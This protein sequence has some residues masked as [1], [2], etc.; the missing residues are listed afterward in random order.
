MAHQYQRKLRVVVDEINAY[1]Y[2]RT[3]SVVDDEIRL[4]QIQ[5]STDM[6]SE[7][8]CQLVTTSLGKAGSYIAL[9]YCWGDPETKG[10]IIVSKRPMMVTKNLISALQDLRGRGYLRIWADAVCINQHNPEEKS[11]QILRM[12]G[13]Y[14]SAWKVVA[15]LHG[16]RFAEA[17]LA[18]ALIIRMYNEEKAA[19]KAMEEYK[20]K[21]KMEKDLGRFKDEG[22]WSKEGTWSLLFKCHQ[23]RERHQPSELRR[24][25]RLP[26]QIDDREH[27]VLY[28][29]LNNPYWCRSWIIQ[30]I[31]ANTQLEIIWG[32][33]RF[34]L[35]NLIHVGRLASESKGIQ[36]QNYG[37]LA[38]IQDLERIRTAQLTMQPHSIFQ[39]L[40]LTRN[41]KASEPRDRIYAIL[42]VTSNG[43]IL[44]PFPN[45]SLPDSAVNRDITSR[46]I[47]RTGRLD[48]VIFK[49]GEVGPWWHDWFSP[50]SFSHRRMQCCIN[51]PIKSEDS[52]E[53]EDYYDACNKRPAH[54]QFRNHSLFVEGFVVDDIMQCSPTLPEALQGG[55]KMESWKYIKGQNRRIDISWRKMKKQARILAW[56]LYGVDLQD[57]FSASYQVREA[58]LEKLLY[59]LRKS[60]KIETHSRLA[61]ELIQWLYCCCVESFVIK[62]YPLTSWLTGEEAKPNVKLDALTRFHTNLRWQMRL[63]STHQGRLGWFNRNALPGDKIA[64]I[65]GC[66]FPAVLRKCGQNRY[67]VVGEAIVQGLMF[68]EAMQEVQT[69]ELVDLHQKK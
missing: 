51:P 37:Q 39:V 33:H 32:H 65:S 42:G 36:I 15:F 56:L 17:K 46:M 67:C 7:I 26:V 58:D 50:E 2:E 5:P 49:H 21:R 11:Q 43:N 13:I 57:D 55:V 47:Q 48:I 18:A 34:R 16:A 30:E 29:L 54:F 1:Q 52:S 62:G 10:K 40:P 41:T 31:S 6:V 20:R 45:Y 8:K 19:R 14:R 63:G 4:L 24:P 35:N 69:M 25:V 60:R 44:V 27:Y 12:A 28:K 64:V 22:E 9:S 53:Y 68:G 59:S 66:R 61:R 38:H 3:L 23:P